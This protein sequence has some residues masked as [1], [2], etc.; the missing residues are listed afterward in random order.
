MKKR[1]TTK[2]KNA[3][4]KTAPTTT[5]T[6]TVSVLQKT[7]NKRQL[8]LDFS[9]HGLNS[10]KNLVLTESATKNAENQ[11]PRKSTFS[12]ASEPPVIKVN[13]VSGMRVEASNG[14][15]RFDTVESLSI[16]NEDKTE[17]EA[18]STGTDDI[19]TGCEGIDRDGDEEGEDDALMRLRMSRR[20]ADSADC[21]E[22]DGARSKLEDRQGSNGHLSIKPE[23]VEENM[24]NLDMLLPPRYRWKTVYVAAFELA[25]DTVLPEEAF[26]FTDEEHTLFE[27]YRALP[28]DPKHLFVRLF[29]RKQKFWFRQSKLENR[30][31]EVEDLN[32]ALQL[33]ISVGLLMDQSALMDPEEALAM[34][35]TDELKLLARRVGIIESLSGKQRIQLVTTILEHFRQQSFIS[36]RLLL[37]PGGAADGGGGDR[38]TGLATH[39][40]SGDASKRDEALIN[41]ITDISGPCVKIYPNI[42][43][44]FER[45]HLVFYRARV[46][47]EG[48]ALLKAI[49][50]KIGQRT[51]PTYEITRTN[52]VFKSQ[53]EL[54]KYE[55]AIRLHFELSEMIDS[56]M[57][58]G[59]KAVIYV[60]DPD[61][62]DVG[63]RANSFRRSNNIKMNK[64]RMDNGDIKPDGGENDPEQ[65]QRR[66][67]V[68]GIYEKVIQEAENIRDAWRQYITT[69]SESS[70]KNP[71][72]FLLRFTPGWV[73]TQ[74]LRLELRALAFLKRFEE[75]SVLLHELLDQ[76][77]YSLGQRGGWYERLALIK[78]NYCFN[79]RLGKQEALQVCMMALRD[80]HVHAVDA[81]LIQA[82]IVRLESELR[83]PFRDRHDFS[84]LALR[85][86]QTRILTGERL[87]TPGTAAPSYASSHSYSYVPNSMGSSHP[88]A[89]QR[90]LWRNIDGSDCGVEE[91]ALSYYRT[92]GYKGHHSE[93]SI[94][95]T[96]F[97]L[98]F[99]DILFSPQPGVFE[100]LYQT[101]PLDLRTDAFFLQ[102][103]ELIMDRIEK[104]AKSTILDSIEPL[105]DHPMVPTAVK[106]EHVSHLL[107]EHNDDEDDEPLVR[108]GRAV[109]PTPKQPVDGDLMRNT[110]FKEEI[111]QEQDDDNDDEDAEEQ[112]VVQAQQESQAKKREDCY[113]LNLIQTHDDL[114][115][116]KKVQ[117]VG[118]NWTF[119]KEELL[120][121][122]ECI[123]G[124]ALSEIC[125]ILA[126][127]YNKRCSGMPDL[128]CWNYPKKLVKFVEVKGPGDRL[129]SKQQ[130]WIDLLTSL[131][132]DV[133]LCIVQVSK[134]EDKFFEE[135][136]LQSMN[137]V[138]DEYQMMQQH[139]IQELVPVS[140]DEDGLPCVYLCDIDY[141][142]PNT[143][144]VSSSGVRIPFAV[145][146]FGLP[147]QPLRIPYFKN[148]V[149]DVESDNSPLEWSRE[150]TAAR[151]AAAAASATVTHVNTVH[152]PPVSGILESDVD[153]N[154]HSRSCLGS[155]LSYR[156]SGGHNPESA[157]SFGMAESA[158]SLRDEDDE[159]MEQEINEEEQQDEEAPLRIPRSP[160]SIQAE[161]SYP[162][163]IDQRVENVTTVFIRD[164]PPAFEDIVAN[165]TDARVPPPS[166]EVFDS[167]T[168]Q[169][170]IEAQ[171][172]HVA[173][174]VSAMDDPSE[175]HLIH[176]RIGIIKCIS[177]D[178]LGQ[179]YE[180]ES[181]PHPPLFII[182]PENPLQWSIDN[183]LHNK[184][185]LYFLC[186][187]CQYDMSAS[188]VHI[189]QFRGAGAGNYK[190]NVHVDETRGF[191][192]RMDQ[193]QDQM[194]LIKFG[195]Y[196][197]HLLRMLQYGV[198]LEDVFVAAA[199]DRYDPEMPGTSRIRADQQR[200]QKLRQNVERSL[201][202][203]EALLGDDYDDEATEVVKRLDMNDF[204]IL[205]WIVKRAPSLPL[206]SSSGSMSLSLSS[207]SPSTTSQDRDPSMVDIHQGGSGLYKVVIG[208]GQVRWACDKYYQ[209]AYNN[210]D[211]NSAAKLGY[212]QMTLDPHIRS[213]MMLG[214]D[215]NQLNTRFITVSKLV[216]LFCVDF[217]LNWGLEASQLQTLTN[218]LIREATSIST[219]AI[220][221]GKKAPPLAWRK[222]VPM[223]NGDDQPINA[224]V[225]LI[226]NRRVRHLI[227]E[228][229]IDLMTVPNIGT[230]DFSNLIILS[231]MKINNRGYAH[232]SNISSDASIHSNDTADTDGSS[233]QVNKSYSQNTFIPE[234]VSFLQACSLLTE[235]SLGFPDVVPG[236]IRILQACA[237]NLDHLRRLDLFR[238]LSSTTRS[239]SSSSS[240][241]VGGAKVN[242][243]LELSANLSTTNITRL[244]MVEC[245]ANN[246]GKARL[247]ESLEELLTDA[248]PFLEDLE[249][250]FMGFNDKHAHALE[251]G[252]RPFTGTDDCRLRRLVIHGK[253]L[254]QGGVSALRRVL[255]R[256]TRVTKPDG[257]STTMDI[258]APLPSRVSHASSGT[259]MVATAMP[260]EESGSPSFG[261]MLK[262]TTLIHLELCSIDSLDD[263]DW[264]RLLTGLDLRRL[265]TLNLQG[266]WFGDRAMAILAR[267]GE[268]C[269][270]DTVMD[271]SSPPQSPL[272]ETSSFSYSSSSVTSPTSVFVSSST[273]MQLQTFQLNCPALSHKGVQHLYRFLSRLTR[274]SNL[275]LHGLRRVTSD[276]WMDILSRIVYRW[277]EVVD[278]VSSGFDDECAQYL[279]W[280]IRGRDQ[281]P[282][283]LPVSTAV[284]ESALPAY[285][286]SRSATNTATSPAPLFVTAGSNTRDPLSS[287]LFGSIPSSSS[288]NGMSP[289]L[290]SNPRDR[291][292]DVDIPSTP[293][294]NPSQKYLEIDLRYTDTS[295][296]G[297][298]DLQAKL[299][300]Q[301]KRVIVR[302]RDGEE[303]EYDHDGATVT[304]SLEVQRGL[305]TKA[306]EDMEGTEK[307]KR[308]G[309]S[310]ATASPVSPTSG[311]FS[312]SLPLL[313]STSSPSRRSSSVGGSSSTG[314]HQNLKSSPSSTFL[315]LKNAFSKKS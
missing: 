91:L 139:G 117:C 189:G 191:E 262:N 257:S 41:K 236:H 63:T 86:A 274:L 170:A 223:R 250:R 56:A 284:P 133:E 62:D 97:G 295:T 32:T 67:E 59:R 95:S 308:N 176:D 192:I 235:L 286:S 36:K 121:I 44:V 174:S 82:R 100:T 17:L 190:R 76:Y 26:L 256:A 271:S 66:L 272:T 260:A 94:L 123:G 213:A 31:Q 251:F 30:Y 129:S 182:L 134:D 74:I 245:K 27:T 55:A 234:L 206:K 77:I 222:N 157:G 241:E 159:G 153:L 35:T 179:K 115:R 240:S 280:G 38:K 5:A 211:S 164:A 13:L 43:R 99:W 253:G 294:H 180:A 243:K 275:S 85:K 80:K 269:D 198:S 218:L 266:V 282:E 154:I 193:F 289:A 237:S 40:F 263:S 141:L 39:I 197:V 299:T 283:A 143:S 212:L 158:S 277:I 225:N 160:H 34:L 118:V 293:V 178:I 166:Y 152:T 230:M 214:T 98:L 217:T 10:K 54:L 50:A 215:E 147:M 130:V 110:L 224:I 78:S 254:E 220:R 61:Q 20:T 219:V 46:Y 196:I 146:R 140:L 122:A 273:S 87:N 228:G 71:N 302:M 239:N 128:C 106:K 90:P 246:E 48:P 161:G 163:I 156:D 33:L 58:P 252:T 296:K 124:S 242:R 183:I 112:R 52:T 135:H 137:T 138:T 155:G 201:A 25:L 209:L 151:I 18:E 29:L 92:L 109:E 19:V 203:M 53:D 314:S 9:R 65:E 119:T 144:T 89:Q 136:M 69:E 291:A 111:K 288:S 8:P 216:S 304:E 249:F 37:A 311:V 167:G 24:E 7:G 4:A 88:T 258:Q 127:E 168:I 204:R 45:L 79:K 2:T 171:I 184:M 232:N 261:T 15:I 297:L 105:P 102:R 202:F 23:P 194:L 6:A 287:R 68:I 181:C 11:D 244:Y 315:R 301:A 73:Y 231:I 195:Y 265:T 185:R 162:A 226:R 247:L 313:M 188:D 148:R 75:E 227:L 12:S 126:Q 142:F 285:S 81:T 42:M 72:Y 51:F 107:E 200:F 57:G 259:V 248:G 300:G 279:V 270:V 229:D 267:T 187:C 233:S 292:N 49:L 113:Y 70:R 125:R 264:A 278:I 172:P 47:S 205:D 84:Y 83:V 221:L 268:S 145:N 169:L 21:E 28:D 108:R 60:R 309:K 101:E 16:I 175:R 114:Y 207:A 104:I 103:Q 132:V 276:D 210:L 281:I 150:A 255:K 290:R 14:N 199:F 307:W 303:E 165:T 186:D 306:R 120:Q 1:G 238:I 96:L 64:S 208:N 312:G 3:A 177:Q 305:E 116:E 298:A 310:L 22:E 131:H 93:N 173:A 149:L